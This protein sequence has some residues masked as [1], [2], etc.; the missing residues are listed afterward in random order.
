MSDTLRLFM[1]LIFSVASLVFLLRTHASA[2]RIR[3]IGFFHHYRLY[4]PLAGFLVSLGAAVSWAMPWLWYAA[5]VLIL[6]GL[7]LAG[8]EMAWA[9]R[10]WFKIVSANRA[11][12][13]ERLR[14]REHTEADRTLLVNLSQ[15]LESAGWACTARRFRDAHRSAANVLSKLHRMRGQPESLQ[16]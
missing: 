9:I 4:M 8:R 10:A 13:S 7:V 14:F 2:R 3:S 1:S 16:Q 6:A 5:G 12:S 15:S 11:L